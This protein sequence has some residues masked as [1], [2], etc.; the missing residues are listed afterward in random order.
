MGE[1]CTKKQTLLKVIT[2]LAI[3]PALPFLQCYRTVVQRL[4]ISPFVKKRIRNE[5]LSLTFR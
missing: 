1:E 3:K 4:S 5:S 2:L